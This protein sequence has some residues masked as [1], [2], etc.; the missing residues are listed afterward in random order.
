MMT[1]EDWMGMI[2]FLIGLTLIIIAFAAVL[3]LTALIEGLT[4]GGFSAFGF[5]L[6]LTGFVMARTVSG[7]VIERFRR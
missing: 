2:L 5:L 1:I 3:K 7:T 4:I 6:C